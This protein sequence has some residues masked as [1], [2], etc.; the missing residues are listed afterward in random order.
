[1]IRNSPY[2]SIKPFCQLVDYYV[3]PIIQFLSDVVF[4]I[5]FAPQHVPFFRQPEA[6]VEIMQERFLEPG[7]HLTTATALHA[8]T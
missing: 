7:G 5:G 8:Q 3:K 2:C 4:R 6:K 1:M